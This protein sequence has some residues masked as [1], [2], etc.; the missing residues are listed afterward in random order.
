MIPPE[1]LTVFHAQDPVWNGDID[2][3]ALTDRD[4]A[5]PRKFWT[6]LDN[7]QM[8]YCSRCRECWF[9]V[10]IDYDGI[11]S[12]CYRKDEKRGPYEPYFFSAEIN[13]T[14]DQ[15]LRSWQGLAQNP[16]KNGHGAT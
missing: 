5:T 9:Q 13:L 11:C 7:D 15:R 14:R 8:E 2:A 12:R 6:K 3:C 1:E 4:K 10:E 16:Y